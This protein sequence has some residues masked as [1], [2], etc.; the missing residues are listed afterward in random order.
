ME[1]Q[2]NIPSFELG[3]GTWWFLGA[4]AF[5]FMIWLFL[6]NKAPAGAGAT[7]RTTTNTWSRVLLLW[8]RAR[9]RPRP[10]TTT[11]NGPG[12]IE[13]II[14]AILAAIALY[15][16]MSSSWFGGKDGIVKMGIV[17]A[18]MITSYGLW[19]LYIETS[20]KWP[21]RFAYT[22][23]TTVLLATVAILVWQLIPNTAAEIVNESGGKEQWPG[24]RNYFVLQ[25]KAPILAASHVF[26][27]WV[28][29]LSGEQVIA[30][31][32][33]IAALKSPTWRKLVWVGLMLWSIWAFLPEETRK[34]I[35]EAVPE[36]YGLSVI[37]WLLLFFASLGALSYLVSKN[38]DNAL[39]DSSAGAN[40]EVAVVKTPVAAKP[41][42]SAGFPWVPLL[43][44]A[45]AIGAI[46]NPWDVR[47]QTI[48]L[49]EQT[50]GQKM[51]DGEAPVKAENGYQ[52]AECTG[53]PTDP[54]VE[55]LFSCQSEQYCSNV[56]C[57]RTWTVKAEEG[58]GWR[59]AQPDQDLFNNPRFKTALIEYQIESGKQKK[60]NF[61][62]PE[63]LFEYSG[64]FRNVTFFQLYPM[65]KARGYFD[66]KYDVLVGFGFKFKGEN[67][68]LRLKP[69]YCQ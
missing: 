66:E 67:F 10:T 3:T 28:R 58:D 63:T 5:F 69:E 52:K 50:L 48:N 1:A 13:K 38:Q 4:V 9:M 45:V 54:C 16:M 34:S 61:R 68:S 32:V 46:F 35:G 57:G 49:F 19:A 42:P 65:E 53:S 20:G 56:T 31:F 51:V 33:L 7:A 47:D 59:Y 18:Q 39:G 22:F 17:I 14:A 41:L 36:V 12:P 29:N 55:F 23:I 62:I 15:Y 30:L 11:A 27:G 8:L 40:A 37:I 25:F 43:V 24:M 44:L 2:A 26:F 60:D 6:R 64:D 21:K